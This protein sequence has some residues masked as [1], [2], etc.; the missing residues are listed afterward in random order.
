MQD[1]SS[2]T[3]DRTCALGS[4]SRVPTTGPPGNS[5][6]VSF[7]PALIDHYDGN[8]IT[9]LYKMAKT[10]HFFSPLTLPF[11]NFLIGFH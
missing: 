3:R 7:R 5:L 1:L 4:E 11:N 10:K 9:V 8:N 2:S 6:P